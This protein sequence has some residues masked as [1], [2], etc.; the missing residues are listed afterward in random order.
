MGPLDAIW[1]LSNFLLAP[2][3]L[4]LI[5][6]SLCKLAWWRTLRAVRW[7]RLAVPAA[8]AAVLIQI[9]FLLLLGRDGRMAT[10]AV[11]VVAVALVLW[12]MAF[13]PRRSPPSGG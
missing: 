8:G 2:V 11:Q 3:G 9:I 6:A 10:Y 12:W 5:A 7:S 1:H 13:G 4:G